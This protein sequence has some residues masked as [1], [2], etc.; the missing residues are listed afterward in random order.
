M[1][2]HTNG[3]STR[4]NAAFNDESG[5]RRDIARGTRGIAVRQESARMAAGRPQGG[6]NRGGWHTRCCDLARI[7]ADGTKSN[8]SIAIR[9]DSCHPE[10]QSL[11]FAA[12]LVRSD[13]TGCHSPRFLPLRAFSS[14]N[15]DAPRIMA[16]KRRGADREVRCVGCEAH[17][18]R[19]AHAGRAGRG[20]QAKCDI[21]SNCR[22]REAHLS[23]D[24]RMKQD[25][26]KTLS[27][28]SKAASRY[29]SSSR[30]FTG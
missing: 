6:K 24:R 27:G 10:T 11:P 12:I 29:T 22:A 20:M 19:G 30:S 1:G 21:E 13:L 23:R 8:D 28:H 9:P 17:K 18:R 25:S 2:K 7:G 14:G 5:I 3:D 15:E 26:R 4:T 16:V